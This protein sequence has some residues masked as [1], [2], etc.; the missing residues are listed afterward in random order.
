[1]TLPNRRLGITLVVGIAVL[2]IA[3]PALAAS[4]SPSGPAPSTSPSGAPAKS[5]KADKPPKAAKEPEVATSVA[6]TVTAAHGRR[7]ASELLDHGERQDLD[8]FGRP[9]LV[10]GRQEPARGL[11][12]Q[13]GHRRRNAR[14]RTRRSLTSRQSTGKRSA[15]QESRPGPVVHGS[16]DRRIPAGRNG[17]RTAS[18]VNGHGRENAPGQLKKESATP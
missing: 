2:A 1:M 12:R 13:V 18:P 9:R 17:W 11:R 8:A 6:G 10:L 16:S 7:R 14:T 4:P 15:R 3:I 5:P